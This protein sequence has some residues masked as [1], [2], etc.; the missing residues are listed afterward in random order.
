M[1]LDPKALERL[2]CERLCREVGV[3]SQPDGSLRLRTHFAFPDGDRYPIWLSETPDGRLRLSDCGHTMMHIG[4]EHEVDNFL[5]GVRGK[6]LERVMTE[7]GLDWEGG[8]FVLDT[9]PEQLSLSLFRFGQ[10]LTQ[11]YDLTFLSRSRVESTFYDDLADLVSH[12]VD[13]ER[14]QREYLPEVPGASAYPVDYR[15]ESANGAPVFL[16]GIPNRDKARLTTIMLSWF[17]QHDLEFESL[18]VFADQTEIPRL[19]LARLSN[20]GGEMIASLEA[21]DDFSRKLRQ[22]TAA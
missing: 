12:S 13:D 16:Y 5:E 8:A 11:I 2:L 14:V 9:A 17:H 15:I 19:D 21:R 22:R 18:L 4:Y 3:D 20:V 1:S 7:S 6:L 10:A